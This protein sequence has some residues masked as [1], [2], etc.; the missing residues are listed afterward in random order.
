MPPD[1]VKVDRS[2]PLEIPFQPMT[3]NLR[4]RGPVPGLDLRENLTCRALQLLAPQRRALSSDRKETS[5]G[6]PPVA[7]RKELGL[8]VSAPRAKASQTCAT[9]P[10]CS[11]W[12]TGKQQ[13]AKRK[14]RH[15]LSQMDQI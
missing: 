9:R 11:S 2:T 14:L 13:R 5:L 1:T 12:Q 10:R 3:W 15:K 4:G 6:R 8:L 7:A